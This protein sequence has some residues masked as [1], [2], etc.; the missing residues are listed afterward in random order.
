[1]RNFRMIADW[2]PINTMSIVTGAA[3]MPLMTAAQTSALGGGEKTKWTC[4]A[5][6]I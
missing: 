5:L 1:M 3:E 6:Q 2:T 4:N